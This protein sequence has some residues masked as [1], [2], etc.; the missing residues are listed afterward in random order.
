MDA[1]SAIPWWLPVVY[2]HPHIRVGPVLGREL[3]GCYDCLTGRELALR[4]DPRITEALW[5]LHDSDDGAGVRGHLPSHAALAAGLSLSLVEEGHREHR[6]LYTYD[7]LSG[8]VME[9]VFS[10]LPRCHR[11]S[12]EAA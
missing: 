10:P 3:P 7:V 1:T 6:A 5:D 8:A 9:H 12:V 11:W 4:K 2:A